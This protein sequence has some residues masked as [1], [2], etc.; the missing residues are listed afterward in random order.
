LLNKLLNC[1]LQETLAILHKVLITNA[2]GQWLGVA[3]SNGCTEVFKCA[4][5]TAFY[6]EAERYNNIAGVTL[7][8]QK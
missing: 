6:K 4:I 5:I 2:I 1:G 3:A 8:W 7:G